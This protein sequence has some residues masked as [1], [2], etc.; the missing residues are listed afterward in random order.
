MGL[1]IKPS[2]L[3]PSGKGVPGLG[4]FAMRT[5]EPGAR[6]ADY[7]GAVLLA[8][9]EA[10]TFHS[11]IRLIRTA[12]HTRSSNSHKTIYVDG[13][14]GC[15]ATYANH[16]ADNANAVV[17]ECTE[18]L[19]MLEDLHSYL[20]LTATMHIDAGTEVTV[21]Y[22]KRYWNS[23]ALASS[24]SKPPASSVNKRL[25]RIIAS[26]EEEEEG[27][28]EG[29]GGEEQGEYS[30]ERGDEE[31]EGE[32]EEQ[33]DNGDDDEEEESS[34]D[35]EEQGGRSE[36]EDDREEKSAGDGEEKDREGGD[37]TEGIEDD[38]DGEGEGEDGR[39]HST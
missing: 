36:E 9:E 28:D 25:R 7:W 2:Q 1:E 19:R 38:D 31:Q 4:L 30:E 34:G 29:E 16:S 13:S 17:E 18:E 37:Q 10:L 3:Q 32:S 23:L 15:P 5:L 8:S 26:S 39:T 24:A 35:E 21:N 33:G 6:I 12:L 27:R 14:K 20:V 22:G 11:S